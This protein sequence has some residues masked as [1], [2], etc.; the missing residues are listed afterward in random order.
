MAILKLQKYGSPVLREKAIPIAKVDDEIR[1]LAENMIETMYAEGGVGLAA[2]Q[3]G[4]S[5]KI[6]VIDI[7]DQGA[8]VLINPEII[9]REGETKEEEGC[10][11]VP[12]IYSPVRRSYSVTVKALDLEEN[13]IRIAQEGFLA[14]ALQHE[15]DHLEGYLFIDRLSPAKRLMIKDQLKEIEK[16]G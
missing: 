8:V 3:V 1:R 6:I 10:L 2:P 4:I 5:K 9:K 16:N 7:E 11:S 13:K 14:I 15:I 12:G